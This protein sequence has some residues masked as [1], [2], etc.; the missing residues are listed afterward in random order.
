MAC[1]I[2]PTSQQTLAHTNRPV[3]RAKHGQSFFYL[4]FPDDKRKIYSSFQ[5]KIFFDSTK[6]EKKTKSYPTNT[7]HQHIHFLRR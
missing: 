3:G 7:H 1:G 4:C 6:D 2:D 5:E